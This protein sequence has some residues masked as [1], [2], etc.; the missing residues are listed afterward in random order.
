[1]GQQGQ[2]GQGR[3]G[4]MGAAQ[5]QEALR[6]SLGRMMRDLANQMGDMPQALGRAE[7]AMRG[8]AEALRQGQP[9]QAVGPQQRAL[10]QLQQGMQAM[11]QQMQQQMGQ[12]PGQGSAPA[13][14]QQGLSPGQPRDPL[15]R[16]RQ[17]GGRAASTDDVKIPD[18]MELQR[19]REILD[20]LRERSGDR[21]RPEFELDYID[22]LL[23]RF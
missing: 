5:R 19:S 4:E 13:M 1:M 23:N 12:Q 15:G 20:E 21:S 18:E 10:D 22:R 11:R 6:R 3:Q 16:S 7:R 14:G 8:A 17:E 2:M 9:G